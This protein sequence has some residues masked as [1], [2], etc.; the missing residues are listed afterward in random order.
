MSYGSR[1]RARERKV[2]KRLAVGEIEENGNPKEIE[3][4]FE[5]ND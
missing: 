3:K 2:I 5:D 4:V 1:S